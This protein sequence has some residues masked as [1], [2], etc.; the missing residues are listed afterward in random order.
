[1]VVRR[2]RTQRDLR[3]RE[4]PED[5]R[6]FYQR[7]L[8]VCE[9]TRSEF[10]YFSG[11]VDEYR[12]S[13]VNVRVKGVGKDPSA[14]VQEA[15]DLQRRER[16]LDE[17]YD[18]IYCVFDRDRHHHFETASED[19]QRNGFELA[20]S[21]PCFEYWLLL[22]FEFSRSPYQDGPG[23]PCE[24]CTKDLRKHLPDY[25]KNTI[26][27]FGTLVHRLG[28]A[29]QRAAAAL[30]DAEATGNP[31]PSTEVHVLVEYLQTLKA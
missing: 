7:V 16:E 25:E 12:L 17:E 18:Q 31:N 27:L 24:N 14:L 20:R 23:T 13:T 26:G 15:I 6:E 29:K 1:M 4:R 22:H 19:A 3:R 11:L 9:G 28:D 8:I 21:W 10:N 30:R 5:R 2:G